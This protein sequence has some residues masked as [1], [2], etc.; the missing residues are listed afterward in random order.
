MTDDTP[1]FERFL[2]QAR[3]ELAEVPQPKGTV[4]AVV[5]QGLWWA[6]QRTRLRRSRWV[7]LLGSLSYVAVVVLIGL[8][9]LE[10]VGT[11][12][13]PN[14][15]SRDLISDTITQIAV[16]SMVPLLAVLVAMWL[17]HRRSMASQIVSRS[18]LWAMT[19]IVVV[20]QWT[21]LQADPKAMYLATLFPLLASAV[22]ASSLTCTGALLALGN[23]G[24]RPP[25]ARPGHVQ[26]LEGLLTLSLVM[27][28][29][30]AL[31]LLT[32]GSLFAASFT[33]NPVPLIVAVW[34]L[35]AAYGLHRRRT[36]GLL[37][38]AAGNLAE[39]LLAGTDAFVSFGPFVLI[40]IVTAALQ[41]LLP[42]PVYFAMARR[43]QQP[44][45]TSTWAR[46]IPAVVL[47]AS[48]ASATVQ[49][50]VVMAGHLF[51]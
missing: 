33:S 44:L 13:A 40:L 14:G 43:K 32:T 11:V 18:M 38:M 7:A 30:D 4:E 35:V 19:M 12:Q 3:T 41:I 48:A 26:G 37:A 9:F 1:S 8:R 46:K 16:A 22:L 15:N 31:V 49:W 20:F 51:P 47:I 17:A 27:G 36:W 5:D 24:L 10:E 23:H 25:A 2:D 50:A 29:A 21:L 39:L 28:L 6:E 45:P 34:L 42:L